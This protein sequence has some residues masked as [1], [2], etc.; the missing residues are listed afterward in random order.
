MAKNK[1]TEKKLKKHF[2]NEEF[3]IKDFQLSWNFDY[4]VAPTM[5]SLN[6]PDKFLFYNYN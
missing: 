3:K 5:A 6:R 2:P 4:P 1:Y